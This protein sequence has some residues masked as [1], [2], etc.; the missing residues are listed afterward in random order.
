ML[1]AGQ[2]VV[3]M[4]AGVSSTCALSQLGVLFCWGENRF[5]ELGDGTRTP[6]P[7][8]TPVQ[9]SL[10]FV[11]VTGTH[12]TS[13]TCA[14]TAAGGAYCWGYN[15]NGELGDG[16][17][18]DRYLPAPVGGGVPFRTLSSSYHTCGVGYDD[19]AYCWGLALGGALGNGGAT[20][21]TAQ[22]VPVAGDPRFRSVTNGM[23]FSC[24]LTAAGIGYCWGWG[25]MLGNGSGEARLSPYPVS[26]GLT[27][28]E[29]SAG[30]EHTCGL[31]AAGAL[32][33]W[34]KANGRY[35]PAVLEPLR[36]TGVPSFAQ[37]A[38]GDYHTCALTGDGIAY[39]WS[40]GQ[41]PRRV[42]SNI[43]FA[44]LTGGQHYACGYTP[45]GAAYC[46]S[47]QFSFGYLGDGTGQ[48]DTVPVR[49]APFPAPAGR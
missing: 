1:P 26:G 29:L 30:E 28:V 35:D 13:R 10:R 41:A 16:S 15:L 6:R 17:R 3:A 25:A 11:S 7:L 2:R 8:P 39:C 23:E 18:Q 19:R 27:F 34:G 48:S 5:G 33:C 40:T 43:R 49:V 20:G 12:G 37:I 44:G 32:Y 31:T 24:G 21:D 4:A 22:P 14:T 45:G 46:W 36:V 42:P 38:A 9:T 47:T